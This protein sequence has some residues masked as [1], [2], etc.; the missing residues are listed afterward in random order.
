[1]GVTSSSKKL[2]SKKLCSKKLCSKKRSSK[3]RSSKKRSSKKRSSKKRSSKKRSSK[4]L[5]SKKRSSKKRG[6]KGGWKL[7]H[8]HDERCVC[9]SLCV[10]VRWWWEQEDMTLDA[11]FA[12]GTWAVGFGHAN[13]PA[14]RQSGGGGGRSGSEAGGQGGGEGEAEAEAAH[15]HRHFR[16]F[17]TGVNSSKGRE[18]WC[19]GMELYGEVFVEEPVRTM[20]SPLWYMRNYALHSL[21]N[22]I[23]Y[24]RAHMTVEKPRKG[25]RVEEDEDEEEDEGEQLVVPALADVL[26]AMGEEIGMLDAGGFFTAAATMA[27]R[28]HSHSLPT[29]SS[30]LLFA[31]YFMHTHTHT[32]LSHTHTHTHTHTHKAAQSSR[33]Q[34]L[35]G[36]SLFEDR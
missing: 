28:Q 31:S 27:S 35:H 20:T 2:C 11:R 21:L 13:P 7:G 22:A 16:V 14:M 9:V 12:V 3:K 23:L 10:C 5:C 8:T 32:Q 18:L 17:M 26:K 29:P 6:R 30:L 1:V 36:R 25:S 33:S 24:H 19:S 15:V 4:K 34:T